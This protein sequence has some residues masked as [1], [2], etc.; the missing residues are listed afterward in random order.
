MDKFTLSPTN[1]NSIRSGNAPTV[2]AIVPG[3]A[4]ITSFKDYFETKKLSSSA[5]QSVK[6][7]KQVEEMG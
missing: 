3:M 5:N 4:K 6:D 2:N 7:G 1:N